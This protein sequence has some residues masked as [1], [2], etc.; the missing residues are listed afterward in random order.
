MRGVK[1]GTYAFVVVSIQVFIVG[2]WGSQV[3]GQQT[4][5]W[6]TYLNPEF[7]FEIQ[8]PAEVFGGG[9]ESIGSTDSRY[10]NGNTTEFSLTGHGVDLYLSIIPLNNTA[11]KTNTALSMIQEQYDS[12]IK[13]DTISS[14]Q[15]I[16]EVKYGEQK[17]YKAILDASADSVY[18]YASM[19]HKNTALFFY[20]FDSDRTN[21]HG[22][23]FD[24]IVN[25]TKF[26]D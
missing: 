5:T 10:A 15:N 18:V 4:D 3:F 2:G 17:A 11:N 9:Y 24:Q 14:I 1:I 26:F 21:Y 20:M 22:K 16:T 8:Y 23:L 6:N 12:M 7:R 25:S 13:F 19:Q